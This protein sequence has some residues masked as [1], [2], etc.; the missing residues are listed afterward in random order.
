MRKIYSG[1]LVATL[2]V[3]LGVSGIYVANRTSDKTEEKPEKKSEE[4]TENIVLNKLGVSASRETVSDVDIKNTEKD[5]FAKKSCIYKITNHEY[6]DKDMKNIA[7]NLGTS[8]KK[9]DKSEELSVQ[10]DL[11]DG[12]Y[13]SY[14]ENTGGIVYISNN[15]E[16]DGTVGTTFDEAKCKKMAEKFIIDSNITQTS[17]PK[18][19]HKACIN[20]GWDTNQLIS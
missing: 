18:S 19:G 17:H 3:V 8:I 14:F 20:A 12:G 4:Y 15:E 2:A 16:L 1:I 9:T 10:Y 11:K 13:L 7:N 5:V 6:S